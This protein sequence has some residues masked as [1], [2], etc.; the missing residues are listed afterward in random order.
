MSNIRRVTTTYQKCGKIMEIHNYED[1]PHP[2]KEEDLICEKCK[3]KNLERKAE[4][5]YDRQ[6]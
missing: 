4:Y 3:V 2:L 5:E 1:R 6:R